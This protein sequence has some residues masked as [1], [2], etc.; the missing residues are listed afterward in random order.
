MG[1]HAVEALLRVGDTCLVL[2]QRLTAWCG[3]APALE[4]DIALAN[5]ALDILGQARG[6]L[7]R[8]GEIEGAGRDED[9]LAY[10][11]NAPDYRNLLLVEQPNGDYGHTMLRQFLFDAWAVELWQAMTS[12]TDSTVAGIAGKAAK[13]A[14]YHVR[15]SAGWVV[16]LGDGTEESHNRMLAALDLL[17][18]YAGEAFLDDEVDVAAAESGLMP[19]PS[20]LLPA[21]RKHVESVLTE[22]TL[23]VP[24][25]PFWQ[26]GGR[27]GRHSEHLS[28]L[29]T[30]MQVVHRAHPGATW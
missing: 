6:L 29:L 4:E 19:L 10:L 2:A 9:A 17:W 20:S 23:P 3:H 18:P 13:E 30:E 26:R 28:Y 25:D 1:D 22:A 5:V 27:Q 8:A 15:H 12:S 14:A 11:R 24:P 16:R 21:F 7:T